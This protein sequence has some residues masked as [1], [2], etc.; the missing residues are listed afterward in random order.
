MIVVFL[1]YFA[2]FL[3]EDKESIAGFRAEY[4]AAI[5]TGEA[6]PELAQFKGIQDMSDEALSLNLASTVKSL[7]ENGFGSDK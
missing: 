6:I 2:R 3:S 5:A 7:L 1:N 4:A